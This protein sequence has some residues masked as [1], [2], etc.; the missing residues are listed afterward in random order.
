MSPAELPG[1]WR[2]RAAELRRWA[3]AESAAVAL[4]QAAAELEAVLR[5]A[6]AEELTLEQAAQESGYTPDHLRHLV[7]EGAVPNAGRR[8]RPRIRRRDL[9]RRSHAAVSAEPYDAAADA[10]R[11]IAR[12][13]RS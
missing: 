3:A 6:D 11:L 13:G 7:A 8:G 2:N 9:P 10:R 12:A 4:E 5:A 1:T